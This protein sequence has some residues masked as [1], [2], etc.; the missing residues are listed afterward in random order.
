MKVR[1][2][3]AKLKRAIDDCQVAVNIR[4]T[5]IDRT[6]KQVCEA[7]GNLEARLAS[8]EADLAIL[9]EHLVT[10]MRDTQDA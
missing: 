1:E 3:L 7:L 10:E 5:G 6:Q 2:E 8:M 9:K 4:A